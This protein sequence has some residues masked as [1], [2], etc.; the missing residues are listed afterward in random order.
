MRKQMI[1]FA[2]LYV[3]LT[4]GTAQAGAERPAQAQ[5]CMACHGAE[6]VSDNPDWPNLAGQHETYLADQLEAMRSGERFNAEMAPFVQNLSDQDI[7]VLA[8]WY[9]AQQPATAAN[10]D[11]GLVERGRQLAGA[12][13]ACHG[14]QGR[15]VADE[16]PILA[17]QHAD[18]LE[19][20]L[21]AYKRDER[22]HP[23]MQAAVSRLDEEAFAALAAYYSQL[24]Y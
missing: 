16:W 19:T 18:Y 10:G 9:S 4:S 23:L 24:E 5:P 11:A 15:P 20:Q 1:L 21:L 2:A 12:C 17:G 14:Y 8:A 22:I 13:S 6:G 7:Q 3:A